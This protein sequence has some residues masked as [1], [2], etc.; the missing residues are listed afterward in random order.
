VHYVTPT[1]DNHRQA[2]GMKAHGLFSAVN[3]EVGEI[4]VADVSRERVAKLMEPDRV[5]L[6]ALIDEA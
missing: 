3:D 2:E 6:R 1:E 5:A 4:I